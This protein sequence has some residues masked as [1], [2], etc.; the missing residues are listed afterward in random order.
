[1]KQSS[2]EIIRLLSKKRKDGSWVHTAHSLYG[3]SSKF[4]DKKYPE[5]T[6]RYYQMKIRRPETFKKKI[7]RLVKKDRAKRKLSTS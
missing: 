2:I 5:G 7:A 3:A 6:V 4:K 1:M